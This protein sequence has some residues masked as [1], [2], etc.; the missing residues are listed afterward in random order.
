MLTI[1]FG[2]YPKPVL[3]MSAASV[4]QLLNSYNQAVAPIKRA[5]ELAQ[6][7]DPDTERRKGECRAMIELT[8]PSPEIVLA[9]ARW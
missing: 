5:D 8:P 4:T 9:S 3:D 7:D 1:F 2:V 6:G